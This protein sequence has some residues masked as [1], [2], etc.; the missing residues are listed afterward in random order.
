MA[1]VAGYS[2]FILS[3][4]FEI[5]VLAW[6][7]CGRFRGIGF[8]ERPLVSSYPSLRMATWKTR[9]FLSSR[10]F[11]CFPI[12]SFWEGSFLNTCSPQRVVMGPD[13]AG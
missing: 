9:G 12:I 10:F 2:F 8:R 5:S 11:T 7:I 3:S 4:Y 6:P 1:L 13:L